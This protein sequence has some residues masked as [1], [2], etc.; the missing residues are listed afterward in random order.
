MINFNL[1]DFRIWLEASPERKQNL[2][3]WDDYL[4]TDV[5]FKPVVESPRSEE[6]YF[7]RHG[8]AI[9]QWQREIFFQQ[10]EHLTTQNQTHLQA[11]TTSQ[12]WHERQKAEIIEQWKQKLTNLL[13]SR[14]QT[15]QQEITLI[16]EVL[17]E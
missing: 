4:A 9:R 13:T 11:L 2:E 14:K 10:I 1:E 3:D 12:E 16:K 17:N 6:C 7:D 15:L 5:Y 8:V